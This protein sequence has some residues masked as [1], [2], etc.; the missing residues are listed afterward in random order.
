MIK[1]I[2]VFLSLLFIFTISSCSLTDSPVVKNVNSRPGWLDSPPDKHVCASAEYAI[3]GEN[4]ARETALQ[5][6]LKNLAVQKAGQAD[7]VSQIDNLQMTRKVNSGEYSRELATVHTNAV[8]SGQDIPVKAKVI[9]YW[10]DKS[11]QQIWIL[12]KDLEP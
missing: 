3:F 1:Y 8:I 12:I 2:S 10:K 5:K 9:K 4:K 6:A 11:K 7:V